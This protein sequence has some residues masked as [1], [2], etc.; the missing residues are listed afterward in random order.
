MEQIGE[1]SC[2]A[3]IHKNLT[4]NLTE[5]RKGSAPRQGEKSKI[6]GAPRRAGYE[7]REAR[8]EKQEI[9]VE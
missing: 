3:K 7:K 9:S 2:G 8:N 1:S 5:N 4:K 6:Q